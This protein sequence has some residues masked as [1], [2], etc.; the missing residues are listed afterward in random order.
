[1]T[2]LW[3]IDYD[4]AIPVHGDRP[5]VMQ[6]DREPTDEEAAE[7]VYA[8]A[9]YIGAVYVNGI[10]ETSEREM[11]GQKYYLVGAKNARSK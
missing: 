2:R 9:H 8:T 4:S 3:L 1:M 5:V 7:A 11:R 10:T 6:S